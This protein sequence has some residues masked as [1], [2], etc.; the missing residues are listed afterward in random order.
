MGAAVEEERGRPATPTPLVAAA[1][2]G[3]LG[4]GVGTCLGGI[5]GGYVGEAPGGEAPG[6]E[7]PG[8]LEERDLL[9]I[10]EEAAAWDSALQ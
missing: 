5:H 6:G 3:S 1:G 10:A 4:G 8:A 9:A 7:T 2:S